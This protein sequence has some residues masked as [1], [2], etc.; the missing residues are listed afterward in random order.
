LRFADLSLLAGRGA[1]HRPPARTLPV[2]C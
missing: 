1:E 2:S